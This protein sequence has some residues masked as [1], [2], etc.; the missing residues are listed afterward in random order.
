MTFRP[1]YGLLALVWL[2]GLYWLSSRPDL[3]TTEQNAMARIV[4]NLMH[5][6]LFAGLA[7]YCLKS[8]SGQTVSWNACGVVVLVTTACAAL[9]EWHQS[10]VPGRQAS[11]S[12]LLIDLLGTCAMLLILRV[13][14]GAGADPQSP[15]R[16]FR[17]RG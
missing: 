2:G 4:S 10:F 12:D 9:L 3:S 5:A 16:G 6:P 14:A 17:A 13:Q 8:V 1:R 15:S 11:V 7:F